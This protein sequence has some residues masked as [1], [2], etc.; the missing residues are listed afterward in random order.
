MSYCRFSSD[1]YQCDVYAYDSSTGGIDVHVAGRR[2]HIEK[3]LLPSPLDFLD[4]DAYYKRKKEVDELLESILLEPI[5][6]SRDGESFVGLNHKEA[7]EI[8]VSLK[9]EGYNVPDDAIEELK[10]EGVKDERI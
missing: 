1:D 7:I 6:L 2:K 9:E 5:G 3:G 4:V 8:L 10:S